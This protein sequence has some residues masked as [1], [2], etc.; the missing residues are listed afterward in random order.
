ML[1]CAP[2]VDEA[3]Q[4]EEHGAP[5]HAGMAGGHHVVP[6]VADVPVVDAGPESDSPPHQHVSCDLCCPH[7]MGGLGAVPDLQVLTVPTP[8]QPE[9][10][11]QAILAMGLEATPHQLP[12]PPPT[13]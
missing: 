9:T 2:G 8:A 4:A 5:S 7:G 10:P 11:N 12:N 13:V 3:A 6:D 1:A